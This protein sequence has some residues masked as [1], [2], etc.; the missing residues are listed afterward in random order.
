MIKIERSEK[1]E[2]L[3]EELQKKLTEEFKKHKEKSVWNKPFIREKLLEESNSKCVYCECFIGNGRKE[4]HIDHF[5]YKDKY[6]EEVVSWDNLNPSCPHCNKSK[7][8]HDTYLFPIINPFEQNPKDY[9]YLKNYRYYSRNNDVEEIVR[10][11]IS[12]LGLNDTEKVVKFRFEQAEILIDKIEDIYN[13]ANE[14]KEVLCY[15]IRKK[16]RVLRGCHNLLTKGIK[17]AEYSAY[18]ATVIKEN[19][20]YSRLKQILIELNLW[21][22]DLYALDEEVGEMK[23]QTSRDS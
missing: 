23:M 15:D 19:E 20:Y 13:F 10:N 11:T 3:T 4:M 18:M 1:P 5:H 2:Q 21:D 12:V 22:E 8:T 14:N 7:S 9:F 6:I 16:N 17:T